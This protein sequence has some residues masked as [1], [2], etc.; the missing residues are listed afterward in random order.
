MSITLILTITFNHT[1][2]VITH[3]TKELDKRET[4]ALGCNTAN[5]FIWCSSEVK[6]YY[7]VCHVLQKSP[8]HLAQFFLPGYNE[9]HSTPTPSSHNA[10]DRGKASHTWRIQNAVNKNKCC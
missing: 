2:A 4:R 7:D 3:I 9:S 6:R 1:V 5:T 8:F 10:D